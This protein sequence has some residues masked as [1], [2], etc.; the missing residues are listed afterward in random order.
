MKTCLQ[1]VQDTA[2]YWTSTKQV[3]CGAPLL[4]VS[5]DALMLP[6][7][8]PF[9]G[10]CELSYIRNRGL[11]KP[12]FKDLGHPCIWVRPHE[13]WWLLLR[14]AII[15]LAPPYCPLDQD[16]VDPRQSRTVDDIANMKT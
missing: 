14:A 16:P 2:F 10:P 4:Y 5:P 13:G 1:V 7:S 12:C 9:S 3:C 6:W 8:W 11:Q 15:G